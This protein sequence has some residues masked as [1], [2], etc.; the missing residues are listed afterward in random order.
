MLVFNPEANSYTDSLQ[1]KILAVWQD[2]I[3]APLNISSVQ[4]LMDGKVWE[5]ELKK[6]YRHFG[7]LGYAIDRGS[8]DSLN[9]QI[10]LACIITYEK[11]GVFPKVGPNGLEMSINS[12]SKIYSHREKT[13]N[14]EIYL[15]F[16]NDMPHKWA[17]MVIVPTYLDDTLTY[18]CEN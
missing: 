8:F 3:A 12:R 6:L 5:F 2:R 13:F 10:A 4:G 14:I 1:Q 18:I 9:Y 7:D 11:H 16:D 15:H 17:Q